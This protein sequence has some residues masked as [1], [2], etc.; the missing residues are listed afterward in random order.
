MIKYKVLAFSGNP[1]QY[2]SPLYRKLSSEKNI[3]LEV[4]FGDDIGGK[5]FFSKEFNATISWD[6]PVLDGYKYK[7]FKNFSSNQKKGFLSRNNPGIFF[8]VFRNSSKFVLLHGYDT[9]SSWYVYLA[10][11]LSF[12]KIIWRGEAIDPINEKK[13]ISKR[14]SSILKSFIL[15]IYFLA[16]YRVLY[17]CKL[18]KK[19]LQKY[20]Y[21]QKRKLTSFPCAVDNI[22]FHENKLKDKYEIMNYKK[23]LKIPEDNIVIA[24]CS[25]LT[26]RKR[27][28]EIID[29]MIL[30]KRKDITFLMIGDGPEKERLEKK[31]LEAELDFKCT[32]F[33]GQ[34]EVAKIL[35][36][37]DIFVLISEYD[38]SPKALN[39]AMNFSL[40]IIVSSGV[41]TSRDLV[42]NNHNGF[43][44]DNY[45]LKSLMGLLKTLF[46]DKELRISMGRNNAGIIKKYSLEEDVKSF[47]NIIENA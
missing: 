21:F 39:E 16:C 28:E 14:I 27:T 5:P 24:S 1:T 42:V 4:L 9:L 22:F 37:A 26:R 2:H 44:I 7:F 23:S 6:V 12:K 33:V 43:I 40:P 11:I 36:I 45:D 17:S 20:L 38:A 47:K 32:G 18:N 34:L 29:A 25:R 31:S 30:S 8:Y 10:S 41:G 3:E 35:S 15:P 46:E 13:D 19:Y